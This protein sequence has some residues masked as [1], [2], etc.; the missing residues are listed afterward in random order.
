MSDW[1]HTVVTA[2]FLGGVLGCA[3]PSKDVRLQDG[4]HIALI[5]VA[6]YVG[7][8]PG[9]S[10]SD[11]SRTLTVAY[12]ADPGDSVPVHDRVD[13]VARLVI[14]EAE[15]RGDSLVLVQRTRALL[16]RQLPF[17][18]QEIYFVRRGRWGVWSSVEERR[19]TKPWNASNNGGLPG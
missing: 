3:Q 4:S 18:R 11:S 17:V 15:T 10:L 16:G 19:S 5:G 12:Y 7:K 2:V 13:A 1:H 14:P 9:S 8:L 6:E